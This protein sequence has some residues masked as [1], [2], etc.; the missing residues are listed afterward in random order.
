LSE[1]LAVTL[2]VPETVA[3]EA[4]EVMLT[5][6]GV[7]SGLGHVKPGI[8]SDICAKAWDGIHAKPK[9]ANRAAA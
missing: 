6:G 2:I 7:L 3:P 4:G 9:I 5:V 1:A 8:H